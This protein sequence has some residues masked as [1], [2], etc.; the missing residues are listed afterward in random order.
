MCTRAPGDTL[1][2]NLSFPAIAVSTGI[3]AGTDDGATF[4]ND[5]SVTAHT[6]DPVPVNN[7]DS[8]T[9]TARR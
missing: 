9:A 5:V 1:G 4:T 8:D 7:D 6:H 3:P 2:P